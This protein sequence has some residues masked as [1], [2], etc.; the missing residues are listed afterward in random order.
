M[1]SY[2]D[3][4]INCDLRPDVPQEYIDA[5]RYLTST[6][7]TVP[8]PIKPDAVIQSEFGTDLWDF[9]TKDGPLL[10]P[11]PA[12]GMISNFYTITTF[13]QNKV[14]YTY[15]LQFMAH[16]V[17]DDVWADG[18]AEFF[19]WLPTIAMDGLIGYHKSHYSNEVHLLYAKADR[20][21]DQHGNPLFSGTSNPLS[22]DV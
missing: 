14:V 6:K 8:L 3:V 12:N 16:R 10:S 19:Y 21:V 22:P 7:G 5:I 18:L 2:I 17:L 4:V 20:C 1:S 11:D 15:R 9:V 13:Y